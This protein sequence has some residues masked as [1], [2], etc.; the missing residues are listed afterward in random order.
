M[1]EVEGPNESQL[2]ELERWKEV[3]EEAEREELAASKATMAAS[4]AESVAV[5]KLRRLEKV[6]RVVGAACGQWT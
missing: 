4:M 2:A 3:V 5:L 6:S 1:E